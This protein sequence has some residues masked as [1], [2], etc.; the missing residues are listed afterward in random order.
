[1]FRRIAAISGEVL[2]VIPNPLLNSHAIVNDIRGNRIFEKFQISF[3]WVFFSIKSC[4][5]GMFV[6][7]K[8]II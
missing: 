3:E 1:M 2:I 6:L 4:K 5:T 7:M 8:L